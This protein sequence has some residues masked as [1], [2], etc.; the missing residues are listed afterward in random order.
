MSEKMKILIVCQLFEPMNEIGAVRPTKLAHFLSKKGYSVDVFTSSD[1]INGKADFNNKPYRL[2]YDRVIQDS[3]TNLTDSSQIKK[4]SDK[5]EGRIIKEAKRTYRQL[6][7]IKKGRRFASDFR[8]SIDES[9]INLSYYDFVFSTFG[10]IGSIYAGAIAKKRKKDIKWICDFR[11]PMVSKEMPILLL[12]YLKW[13]QNYCV[14]TAD[15]ITTVSKGYKKRIECKRYSKKVHVI[16][17][18]YDTGDIKKKAEVTNTFSFAYV[19]ALY[20]GKRD[21]GAFFEGLKQVMDSRIITKSEIEFHYAG[22][23]FEYLRKQAEPYGLDEIL[24]NHGV[25]SRELSFEIQSSSRYLVLST[26]NEIGEEGVFPGKLI[27]YMLM[28]KPVVSI[29]SGNLSNSE[30]TDVIHELGLGYSYETMDSDKKPMFY[31]WL[32]SEAKR[33]RK[34]LSA[35]FCPNS[36]EIDKRYNWN[37]IVNC[38]EEIMNE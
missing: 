28:R 3:E 37:S 31:N 15:Y 34:G 29:V 23:D 10:P 8:Q 22:R 26:W 35:D 11:D 4:K 17:N 16:P 1:G 38:F 20:E 2:I 36:E 27:D 25:V 32:M 19:G 7:S 5:Q 9:I 21:L 12:P 24:I 13:L 18:G 14:G 6:L 30:V 33:F